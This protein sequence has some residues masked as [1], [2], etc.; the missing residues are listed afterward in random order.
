MKS[1]VFALSLVSCPAG[2]ALRVTIT[3]HIL[4]FLIRITSTSQLQKEDASLDPRATS[5]SSSRLK[6]Q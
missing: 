3:S 6:T 2:L 1:T 4:E 5:R